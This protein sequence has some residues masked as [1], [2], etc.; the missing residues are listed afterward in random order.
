MLALCSNGSGIYDYIAFARKMSQI[1]LVFG[2]SFGHNLPLLFAARGPIMLILR[3]NC[4]CCDV[5][6]PYDSL[7]AR[8]CTFECTFCSSCAENKLKSV[9][10][11]CQ[12]ELL[13]RPR[14]PLEKMAKNPAST[15]RV[16]KPH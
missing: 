11:N 7:D 15:T 6:L 10:P 2:V 12:G 9:C 4:E 3:P 1:D 8:I 14:R 13:R 5:D 16:L